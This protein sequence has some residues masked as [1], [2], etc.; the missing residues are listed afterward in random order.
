MSSLVPQPLTKRDREVA[1]RLGERMKDADHEREAQAMDDAQLAEQ[2]S[3]WQ[4]A[5]G[6]GHSP[7]IRRAIESV[8]E[9]IETMGG[10]FESEAEVDAARDTLPGSSTN[11]KERRQ[12]IDEA[13]KAAV[14]SVARWAR[15]KKAIGRK[16]ADEDE[17]DDDLDF[18]EPADDEE[19]GSIWDDDHDAGVPGFLRGR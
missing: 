17:E 10:E 2:E 9:Q 14:E 7:R 15:V 1:R 13:T 3:A 16:D 5:G 11:P 19:A 4:K 18:N 12:Q 6:H 8:S